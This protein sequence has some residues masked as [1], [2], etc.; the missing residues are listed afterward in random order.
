MLKKEYDEFINY[1]EKQRNDYVNKV[2]NVIGEK[3]EHKDLKYGDTFSYNLNDI[4]SN[5]QDVEIVNLLNRVDTETKNQSFEEEQRL[6]K[7]R[8]IEVPVIEPVEENSKKRDIID[9]LKEIKNQLLEQDNSV[10]E[11]DNQ[12]LNM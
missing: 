9:H 8:N 12:G 6:L 3:V 7:E 4:T 11:P 1:N 5:I 10:K 2:S